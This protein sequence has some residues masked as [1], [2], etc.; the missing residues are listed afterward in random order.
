[1]SKDASEGLQ[2]AGLAGLAVTGAV[3]GAAVLSRIAGPRA[4]NDGGGWVSAASAARLL[5]QS[6]FGPTDW[7]IADGQ[8]E[9]FAGWIAKPTSLPDW[10]KKLRRGRWGRAAIQ[11][12][13]AHIHGNIGQR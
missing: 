12:G 4:V 10:M 3:D 9:G 2:P 1:M 7:P 5:T 8:S 11:S 13:F 6:T